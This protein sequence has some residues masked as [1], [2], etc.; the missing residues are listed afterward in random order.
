MS[1]SENSEAILLLTAHFTERKNE[2][3]K[4][5]TTTEWGR[6]A[7]WLKDQQLNPC[8]INTE[9]L[10]ELLAGWADK[11]ITTDRLGALIR[12]GNALAL[13]VEKWQRAGLWVM[14][15]SDSD[16]PKLL[17][18]RLKSASPPVLFGCGDRESL[19]SGGLAVVGSRRASIQDLDFSRSIGAKAASQ[20]VPVIS[21]GAKG[22]DESAMLEALKSGG[23]VIGVVAESL[24]KFSRSMKY[25]QYVSDRKLVLVTPFNPEAR[26]SVPQAM[27]RNKLIYCLSSVGFVVQSETKGG[28]WSGANENLRRKWVPLW[29]KRTAEKRSGNEK[30]FQAGARWA[31]KNVDEIDIVKLV[32]ADWKAET[33]KPELFNV[34]ASVGEEGRE[35]YSTLQP[36]SDTDIPEQTKDD[37]KIG[38][39]VESDKSNETPDLMSETDEFYELFLTKV[40][41]LCKDGFKTTDE[42]ASILRLQSTQLKTWLKKATDEGKLIRKTKP[43][44]YHW[45]DQSELPLNP[46]I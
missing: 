39:N 8:S 32:N 30:I 43:V 24:L 16:Y 13:A 14:T 40:E 26:F 20:G 15:R 35:S 3:V 22:V 44:R 11:S 36:D 46:D 38:Q 9:N 12:R 37:P 33:L 5:L 10:N 6:F 28:T 25:R 2:S 17:K 31:P 27:D 29:V 23:F 42:L 34:P 7:A 1:L 4:P 41:I 45:S 19:N 21:G 18:Q